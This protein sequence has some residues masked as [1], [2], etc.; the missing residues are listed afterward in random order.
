MLN[1]VMLLGVT[2]LC[3]FSRLCIEEARHNYKP[4]LRDRSDIA[5][6]PLGNRNA[7]TAQSASESMRNRCAITTLSLRNYCAATG[8]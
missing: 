2:A 1:K 8:K 4:S 7:I 6:K 3:V 5:A